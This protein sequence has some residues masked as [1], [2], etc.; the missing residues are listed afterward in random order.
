MTKMALMMYAGL[1][2]VHRTVVT[3]PWE[4][5]VSVEPTMSIGRRPSDH[6]DRQDYNSSTEVN[7]DLFDYPQCPYKRRSLEQPEQTYQHRSR[8]VRQNL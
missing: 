1:Q 5:R 7:P 8:D 4:H 3:V 2:D 6:T